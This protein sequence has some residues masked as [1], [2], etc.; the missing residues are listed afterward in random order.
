MLTSLRVEFTLTQDGCE[1][2]VEENKVLLRRYIEEVL[3]QGNV[4]A[5]DRFFAADCVDH[6]APPGTPPGVGGIKQ[7]L[8]MTLAA[9]SN[10]SVTIEDMIA[11]ENKV[12]TRFTARGTHTGEF[13][14]IAPT[15]K[16]VNLTQICIDRVASGKIVEHWGLADQMSLLQQL[17]GM[18][19][20]S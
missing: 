17:G 1:M 10:I 11:E 7:L 20:I 18:P 14:G 5:L 12:V 4:D 2:S 13:M 6:T 16:E 15:G 3:N 8:S 9:F 19:S